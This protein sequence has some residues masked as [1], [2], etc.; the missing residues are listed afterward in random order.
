MTSSDNDEKRPTSKTTTTSYRLQTI[1]ILSK[2]QTKRRIKGE[3]KNWKDAGNNLE[4]NI[5]LVSYD[6]FQL[7]PLLCF[8]L[9]KSVRVVVFFSQLCVLWPPVVFVVF[10]RLLFF[11]SSL[12]YSILY[13]RNVNVRGIKKSAI[14]LYLL[15]LLRPISN[16]ISCDV[17]SDYK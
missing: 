11:L 13:F 10:I 8:I 14:I 15:T 5:L 16:Y 4:I 9:V 6:R 7:M 12:L 2:P 1:M 3:T 17:I